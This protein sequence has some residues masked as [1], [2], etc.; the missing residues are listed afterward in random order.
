MWGMW[1]V[2]KCGLQNNK[3]D[4]LSNFDNIIWYRCRGLASDLSIATAG[5][6]MHVNLPE[7]YIGLMKNCDAGAPI[8]TDFEYYDISHGCKISSALGCFLGFSD[9]EYNILDM[10][11]NPPEFFPEGL[12]AFAETGN[13][14]YICFDYREGKDNPDPLVVY[15]SHE[16]D[17]G[18]DIS[19]IAK[20]FEE[21]LSMLKEPEV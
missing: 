1:A 4:F 14:D 16:A 9:N 8:K 21:F 18:K 7:L 20:N 2:W 10:F 13:G 6:K 12:I 3:E 19:F 5:N 17:V 15:W 11:Q